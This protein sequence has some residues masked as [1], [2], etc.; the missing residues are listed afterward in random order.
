MTILRIR[1]EYQRFPKLN[2]SFMLMLVRACR[3]VLGLLAANILIK[4]TI[5]R[6]AIEIC[7]PYVKTCEE[8]GPPRGTERAAYCEEGCRE[9]DEPSPHH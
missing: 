6:G 1:M 7:A 9:G 4:R 3:F 8:C 5:S 2:L